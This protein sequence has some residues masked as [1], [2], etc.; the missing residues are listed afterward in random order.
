MPL[1][2]KMGTQTTHSPHCQTHLGT[3][4]PCQGCALEFLLDN[5]DL[6]LQPWHDLLLPAIRDW[7]ADTVYSIFL[8]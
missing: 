1:C 7:Q 8:A 5:A 4:H 2:K 6:Q 3:I